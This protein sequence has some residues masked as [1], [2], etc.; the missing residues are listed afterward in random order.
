MPKFL[1]TY[2]G[3]SGVPASPE[4]RQQIEAA[5]IA[6]AQSV[7]SAMVDPGSPLA[8]FRTVSSSGVTDGQASGAIGGYTIVDA[9]DVDGAVKLCETH[10]FVQRGGALQV[11]QSIGL[12]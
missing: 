6:W 10:P 8:N 3:G 11:S 12:D 7:G 4:A 2:H 9:A 5:F 1:I